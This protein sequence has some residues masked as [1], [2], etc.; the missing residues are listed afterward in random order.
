MQVLISYDIVNDKTR[1][2]VHKYLT[3]HGL[4][5]QKSVFECEID[6]MLLD[7]IVKCLDELIDD[8]VDSVRFYPMCRRCVEKIVLIGQG[9]Y[10]F[11]SSYEIV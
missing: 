1:S 5:T 4:N 8:D 7:K 6:K 3:E 2:K 10:V 9:L 11:D